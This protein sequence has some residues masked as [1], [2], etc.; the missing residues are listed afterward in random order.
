[1]VKSFM[2]EVLGTCGKLARY[3]PKQGMLKTKWLF[4]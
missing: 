1:M 4:I 3:L 2:A